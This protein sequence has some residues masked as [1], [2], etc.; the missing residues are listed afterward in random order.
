MLNVVWTI[1]LWPLLGFLLNGFLGRRWGKQMSGLVACASVFVSF[2]ISVGAFAS[3][4]SLENRQFVQTVF[5]WIVAGDFNAAPWTHKAQRFSAA[6]DLGRFNTFSPTWPA[7]WRALPLVPV[8]PIDN[9]FV[10]PQL[11]KVDLMVGRRLES[12]HLPVIAD[13][14]LVD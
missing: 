9:V 3:L 6:T 13:I 14:A 8:L 12:D 1:P 7:R 10:S 11:A 4:L 2:A 5:E